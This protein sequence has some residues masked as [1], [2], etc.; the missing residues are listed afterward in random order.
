MDGARLRPSTRTIGWWLFAVALL[1]ATDETHV[2]GVALFHEHKYAE[3]IGA[4]T[5]AAKKEPHDSASYQESAL[6]VAQ[7]YF[8]LAQAAKAIPWL[9]SIPP[10]NESSYMLGYAYE[11][12]GRKDDAVGAFARLFG[13]KRDSAA[14]HLLTA[15]LLLKKQLE[16]EGAQEA[17]KALAIDPKIPE[18]HF[19]IAEVAM[20]RGNVAESVTH[21]RQ[22]L[23]VNPSFAMAWYRLGDA[24]TRLDQWDAAIVQLQKAVWLNPNF[25]GPFILLGKCYGKKNDPANAIRY[26]RQALRLDP[27][28]YM[29]HFLLGR[30]LVASGNAEEGRKM[31]KKS[32]DLR[33]PESLVEQ[34]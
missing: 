11:Q 22:E 25:S 17:A 28:N 18:A 31:L 1:G 4:L 19:V 12:T 32:E 14:A 34:P 23:A 8:A 24:Y 21:L 26:L 13:V 27:N 16:N 15:Q 33:R 6:L 10:S 9:E 30:A 29:A 5:E 7:S 2:R 3:A 20:F